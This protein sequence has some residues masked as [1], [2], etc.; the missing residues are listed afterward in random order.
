MESRWAKEAKAGH[1][2]GLLSIAMAG[3]GV[4]VIISATELRTTDGGVRLP[5][6]FAVLTSDGTVTW[7]LDV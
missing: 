5:P 1:I 4:S 7:L 6:R 3:H 2:G